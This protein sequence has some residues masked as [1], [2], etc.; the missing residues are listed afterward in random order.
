MSETSQKPRRV[1]IVDDSPTEAALTQKALGDGY[2]FEVYGDGADV[3]ER[4]AG[5]R[6]QPDVILLDFV[7][8]GMS[9]DE[10][11]KFLRAQP[12][13]KDLPIIIVT[14]SRVE[15]SDVVTG[16]SLGANDYV[17]RPFAPEELRA[18]LDSVIRARHAAE[19]AARERSRL[20]TVNHLGRALF[21]AGT[22]IPQILGELA[23]TLTAT[24]CDGCSI[25]LLPGELPEVFV[26]RH[27]G[28]VRA[29]QLSAIAAVADPAAFAFTS[30][31]QAKATLPPAYHAYIDRFGLR[32]LVILPFPI[33][34]P[35][36]GIVTVTRDGAGEPFDGDDLAMI[37]TCIEYAALGVQKALRFET[38]RN[39]RDQLNA[40]L[41]NLPV[42]IIATG[43]GGAVT[44][45]NTAAR[46]MIAG[47]A[48]ART[49]ADVAAL[50]EWSTPDGDHVDRD[51]WGTQPELVMRRGE[52]TVTFAVTR[53]PLRGS[54]GIHAG[55]VTV[56]QDIT[57][58]RSAAQEREQ[59]ARFT[60]RLLGIV[61]HDLRSPL[62]AFVA[63]VS[64][65]EARVPNEA[66]KPVIDRLRSSARRMSRIVDQ[67]LDVTRATLGAGIQLE[68]RDAELLSLARSVADE[69]KLQRPDAAIEI[70]HEGEVTGRWDPERLAQV[71]SNLVTNAM[72]YGRQNAPVVIQVSQSGDQAI[73]A[74]KNELRD[75]PIP[76]DVLAVLF[77]PH[78]RGSE[79]RHNAAG[80]GLGLYIVQQIVH[81]HRGVITAHSD[82]SGTE[83]RV[84][85]PR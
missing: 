42:G 9:G 44:L 80:L 28:D 78:R 60:Q 6:D 47:L 71:V 52:R 64:V 81:A 45:S 70:L 38:E 2:E 11:C 68:R 65:L 62:G 22:D 75:Q 74:V 79:A 36:Q 72:H 37:E 56:L 1:W 67:L 58:E 54:R 26:S 50:A 16:L 32:G 17:A 35:V 59:I 53:V 63:G 8:P 18:R 13:T 49:L 69:L 46:T 40:V 84:M 85:L 39:A 30:S 82:A 31:E 12:S 7:M 21:K 83:F 66:V 33:L 73:I 15:T 19:L 61:G 43:D 10:V 57:H 51:V 41:E 14:A 29:E 77:D 25:L 5:G 34:S 20:A 55:T 23:E 48:G 24:L 27:R 3:V 4:L 76:P